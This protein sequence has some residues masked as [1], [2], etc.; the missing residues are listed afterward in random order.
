MSKDQ[1]DKNTQ[2]SNTTAPIFPL[3]DYITLRPVKGIAA[4]NTPEFL[5]LDAAIKTGQI[6]VGIDALRAKGV[7]G[8]AASSYPQVFYGAGLVNEQ[9]FLARL[10]YDPSSD[11]A[12]V[13][14]NMKPS[15]RIR[16][17]NEVK[18]GTAI[19]GSGDPDVIKLKG[20]AFTSK[21]ENAM[22]LFLQMSNSNQLTVMAMLEKLGSYSTI[23]T[24]TGTSV[25]VSSPEDI[26][27]YLNQ[28]SLRLTGKPM[29]QAMAERMITEYQQRERQAAASNVS[30]PSA[31]VATQSMVAKARPE[32]TAGYS[33]GKAIELAFQALA[34][35]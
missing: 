2:T 22:Q 5:A 4:G 13:L 1:E 25:R 24:S 18:R 19:Y 26:G 35:R 32:E 30:A 23:A 14:S 12:T 21:D 29:T 33:V 20:E 3:A 8:R 6:K 15:D 34:G 9:G 16:W 31:T 27:Y 17:A 7:R 11:A 10:E 28:A